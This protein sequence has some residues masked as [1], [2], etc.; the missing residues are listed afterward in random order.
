M[1]ETS[2]R[3]AAAASDELVV[4][5]VARAIY[6]AARPD[7]AST[8]NVEAA[9]TRLHYFDLASAA[10]LALSETVAKTRPK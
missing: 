3:L 9:E 5:A 4:E 10:I 8:W 2:G 6:C 7:L 1:Y